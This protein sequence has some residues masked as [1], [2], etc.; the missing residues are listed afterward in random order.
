MHQTISQWLP[1]RIGDRLRFTYEAVNRLNGEIR[2][3]ADLETSWDGWND[4]RC[5]F[6]AMVEMADEAA[7]E[8]YGATA[9]RVCLQVRVVP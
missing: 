2:A 5:G 8:S 3:F 7:V 9:L 6:R 4:W 1:P